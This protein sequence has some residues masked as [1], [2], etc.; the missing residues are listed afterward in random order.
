[1]NMK[2]REGRKML[3]HQDME[4]V[5]QLGIHEFAVL[6]FSLSMRPV[7]GYCLGCNRMTLVFALKG[8]TSNGINL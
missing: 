7:P 4:E 2:G 3:G 1:M 5:I 8:E 6:K